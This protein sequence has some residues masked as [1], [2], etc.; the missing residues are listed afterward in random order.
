[1]TTQKATKR[2]LGSF[3]MLLTAHFQILNANYWN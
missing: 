2:H 1:M 3:Q